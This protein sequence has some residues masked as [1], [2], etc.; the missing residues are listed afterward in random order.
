MR[1]NVRVALTDMIRVKITGR[2]VYIRR[3]TAPLPKL[4]HLYLSFSSFTAFNAA[5]H[6]LRDWR[7]E[8]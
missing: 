7:Y 4:E 1:G 6:G 8:D 3:T 2:N 5:K